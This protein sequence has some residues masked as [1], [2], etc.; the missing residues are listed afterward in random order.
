MK[1][2]MFGAPIC[3]ECVAAKEAL[4]KSNQV[5]IE[6]INITETTANLKEFLKYRDSEAMFDEIKKAGGIGIPF[7]I[8]EDGTKTFDIESHTGIKIESDEKPVNA[9]S[10]DGKGN[11]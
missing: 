1:I 9:C 4:L 7:F 8:L 2:K 6:Y 3:C 5:E 10:L 11:C